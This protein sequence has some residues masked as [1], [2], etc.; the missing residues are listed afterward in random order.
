MEGKKKRHRGLRRKRRPRTN[1]GNLTHSAP[2]K[3]I[4][5]SEAQRRCSANELMR[6]R[7][8]FDRWTVSPQK[9]DAK[10]QIDKTIFLRE[11]LGGLVPQTIAERMFST[12]DTHKSGFLT[13]REFICAMAIFLH[14]TSNEKCEFVFEIYDIKRAGSIT[15]QDMMEIF[16]TDVI[17]TKDEPRSKQAILQ[18]S[19]DRADLDKDGKL[20]FQGLFHL[21]FAFFILN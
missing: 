5:Y 19:F 9:K 16:Q 4:S 18:E 7:K 11:V 15:P 6:F 2:E 21:L 12:F 3:I 14:G 17:L 1:M 20:S 8:S 10:R 13:E